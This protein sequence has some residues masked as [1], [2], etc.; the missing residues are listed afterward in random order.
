MNL[1]SSCMTSNDVT[2]LYCLSVLFFKSPGKSEI[3]ENYD[4]FNFG[5]SFSALQF[6][7]C[8]KDFGKMKTKSIEDFSTKQKRFYLSSS[9]HDNG[10]LLHTPNLLLEPNIFKGV[11]MFA[12][13]VFHCNEFD[14]TSYWL[15]LIK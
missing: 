7:I 8:N 12:Q 5:W 2:N 13:N 4:I 10:C 3:F 14:S 6:T 9:L 15:F 11:L 1:S